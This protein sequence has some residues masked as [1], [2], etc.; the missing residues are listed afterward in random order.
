MDPVNKYRTCIVCGV[1]KSVL[2]FRMDSRTPSGLSNKCLDC[3]RKNS[4]GVVTNPNMSILSDSVNTLKIQ[5]SYVETDQDP[6]EQYNIKRR[7]TAARSALRTKIEALGHY[8]AECVCCGE[9]AV[10]FLTF[11]H[12]TL[13]GGK[14][15]KEM[16]AVTI[17]WLKRHNYPENFE[18]LCVNCNVC[19]GLH[20]TCVHDPE[21]KNTPPE[22]LKTCASCDKTKS[23]R[24]FRLNIKNV[25]SIQETCRDCQ[26]KTDPDLEDRRIKNRR[27]KI[28]TEKNRLRAIEALGGRCA[29]CGQTEPNFL[30]IDH[31]NKKGALERRNR[32][33][34]RTWDL[35][36]YDGYPKDKYRLLCHNCNMAYGMRNC[37]PH[38]LL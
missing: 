33:S 12:K 17:F 31:I 36:R 24:F 37:C 34:N 23:I 10:E 11:E 21:G 30:A 22:Q 6:A 8:G 7:L 28:S 18:I 2:Y 27:S 20:G 29:C 35:A 25:D 13:G 14:H 16:K 32:N 1:E 4:K 3:G 19:R 38:Q 9:S 15:R 5:D 26:E